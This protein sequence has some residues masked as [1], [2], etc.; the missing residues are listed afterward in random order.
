M[1][2]SL[3]LLV[4]YKGASFAGFARQP[5][6]KTVQGQLEAALKIILK[7]EVETVGAGRTDSGV[8]ALGQVVS[9]AITDDEHASLNLFALRRSLEVLAGEDISLRALAFGPAAFSARFDALERTYRYRI[10]TGIERPLF[11]ADFAWHV[12]RALDIEAMRQA[13]EYAKG[14]HDFTS[15][16]VKAS[17]D[18]LKAQGLSLCREISALEIFEEEVLGEACLTIEVRGN[19]F[20]HSMVRTL[21]GTLVEIGSGQHNPAWMGEVIAAQSREAAGQ[22]APAAGLTFFHVRYPNGLFD[23]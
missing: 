20:L 21:V 8:H 13:T 15:F 16:C 5:Q 19:A 23:N 3:I 9:C 7:R 17:A 18:E 6:Q 22:T 4:A 2:A 12:P 1:S 14:E 10:F 11:L